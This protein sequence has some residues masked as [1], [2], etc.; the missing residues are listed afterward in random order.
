M[1]AEPRS[2]LSIL[3][4]DDHAIVREGLKR[5]LEST[6]TAWGVAEADSGFEALELL[7]TGAF[8]IAIMDLSMPGMNGL[9]L[10]RRVRAEFPRLRVLMLSMHAEEQYAMRAF[11]AGANGYVTKDS[12]TRE[13]AAAVRKVAEGGTYVTASLAERVITQLN[14]A[15][16]PLRHECLSDR[17]IEVLRRLVAGHRPTDIANA[18]HLSVK[19]VST[20]KS[21]ILDR[22]QLPNLAA[23][24][25]YGVANGLGME[26]ALPEPLAHPPAS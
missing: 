5:I 26:D 25:R 3:I 14:G 4:V 1:I 21:R 13:L 10:L 18:L 22:L 17:E 16:E 24:I 6:H 2:P 8:D 15:R 9:E 20:H 23:L 12:A 11:K 7:R 19:T